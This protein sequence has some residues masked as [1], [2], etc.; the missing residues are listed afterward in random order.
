M[1][2]ARLATDD[3]TMPRCHAPRWTSLEHKANAGVSRP[4]VPHEQGVVLTP[5][6]YESLHCFVML[7]SFQLAPA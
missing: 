3:A 4:R 2:A 7:D 1:F 6:M 5:S